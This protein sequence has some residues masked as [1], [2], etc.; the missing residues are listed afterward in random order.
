MS[1]HKHKHQ[2][3]SEAAHQDSPS[4]NGGQSASSTGQTGSLQ[5]EIS[6]KAYSLYQEAGYADGRSLEH[7]LAAETIVKRIRPNG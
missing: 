3:S 6:Q 2:P 1:K 5:D 7:W 4:A